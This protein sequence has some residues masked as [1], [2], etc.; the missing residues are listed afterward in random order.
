VQR[1]LKGRDSPW[2]KSFT[3]EMQGKERRLEREREREREEEE[4]L[5][6]ERK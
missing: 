5:E 2:F 1:N 6:R 3:I 4:G